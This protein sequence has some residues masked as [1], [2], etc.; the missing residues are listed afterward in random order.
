MAT[1][2]YVMELAYNGTNYAGWQRQPNAMTVEETIDTALS[3]IL[4]ESI[5]IVGCGRTDAGVHASYYVAHFDFSGELP[6]FFVR[7]YN[8]FVADDISLLGLYRVRSDF[9]AR[10]HATGRSYCYRIALYKDPF[11]QDVVTSLPQYQSQADQASM[12]EAATLLTGYQEFA[13]FCKTNSDAFTM[14]CDVTEARWEFA[15][16]EWVFHIS[17]NRF[18]RGMVRL[19]VGMCL[20]VGEGKLSLQEVVQ[21]L[22][23][24]QSLPKPWSA[25]AAGLFLSQVE[26]PDKKEWE[27]VG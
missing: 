26:Y 20:K 2:R 12:Q 22:E 24:Q 23:Q 15:E 18:L 9:H 27:A 5:K 10:F 17:A 19:I 1:Q 3:T 25:P 16:K 4:G 14:K 13:P 11:R 7:R 8:R 21:A 6:P